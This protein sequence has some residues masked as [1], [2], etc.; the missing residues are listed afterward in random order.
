MK[1]ISPNLLTFLVNALWQVALVAGIAMLACRV[2][3]Q[4]PAS[5]RHAVWVAA[6]I[7]AV[8]LP[9]ASVRPRAQSLDQAKVALEAAGF[10]TIRA[11]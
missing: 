8:L 9:L 1:T 10:R 5:H 4:G 6:L 2:M 3:R 11:W 7:A